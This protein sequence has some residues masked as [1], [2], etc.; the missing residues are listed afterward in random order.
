MGGRWAWSGGLSVLAMLSTGCHA[1]SSEVEPATPAAVTLGPENVVKVQPAELRSGP[2][3]SGTLQAPRAA[4]MRAEVGGRVLNVKAEPGQPVRKDEPLASIDEGT[5][6][7]Q[8]LAARS[9]LRVADNALRVAQSDEA[10]NARLAKAGVITQ[11]DFERAQLAR[12]QAEGQLADARSRLKLAD[13]QLTRTRVVA[14]FDGVISERAVHTGDI[15]QVGSPLFTV[16]DP[17]SLRLEAAVPAVQLAQVKAGTPVE[18]RVTGYGARTF[19]GQVE[20]INPAVDPATGQVRIY[21]DVPNDSR[22]LL[23]GLFAQGRVASI[24]RQGLAVPLDAV[25]PR[26]DPPSV[27]RIHDGK[28]ARAPVTLGLRDEVAQAVEVRSGLEDGDLVLLGSARELAEGTPVKVTPSPEPR[29]S[30]QGVGGAGQGS[31]PERTP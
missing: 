15:V 3:L 27:L 11:R 26:S 8:V 28:V 19:R 7:A 12:T 24:A 29:D 18:F 25:D 31:A 9:S 10:R 22:A 16:V 6:R 1:R 20:H 4:N 21:V 5:L 23:S 13:E 14:P 2:V 17:R 30:G